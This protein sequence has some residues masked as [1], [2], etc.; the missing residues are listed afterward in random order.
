MYFYKLLEGVYKMKKF[1]NLVKLFLIMELR[2]KQ[3]V[4]MSIL[5][6]ILLMTLMGTAGRSEARGEISYMAYIL[7]G[8]L[9][10]AYG[11]TGLIALPVMITSYKE[12]NILKKVATTPIS[13]SKFFM[14]IFITQIM[15]MIVQTVIIISISTFIFR[16]N[17]NI[18][19]VYSWLLIP[20]LLVGSLA[21]LGVGFI[22]CL[23]SNSAKNAT[24]MGNLANLVMM[25]MGGSFFGVDVW[26]DFLQPVIRVLP[27]TNIIEGIRKTIVFKTQEMGTLTLQFTLLLICAILTIS[28]SAKNFRLQ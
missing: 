7:P 14:A 16:V 12:R 8:I 22:I 18:H 2:N 28:V 10:M 25:F 5:F 23:F 4:F 9:G 1:I 20:L 3:A 19:S 17:I 6:P 21:M 27:M 15:F 11:A 13:M 26:P 24:T